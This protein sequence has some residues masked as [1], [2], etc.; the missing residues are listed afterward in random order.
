LKILS[1]FFFLQSSY[2]KNLAI[3]NWDE[4]KK[5]YSQFIQPLLEY[6]T[7]TPELEFFNLYSTGCV[8]TSLLNIFKNEDY[9]YKTIRKF[10]SDQIPEEEVDPSLY[11]TLALYNIGFGKISDKNYYIVNKKPFDFYEA[12]SKEKKITDEQK[13]ALE[14]LYIKYGYDSNE[15]ICQHIQFHNNYEKLINKVENYHFS[16]TPVGKQI[17]RNYIELKLGISIQEE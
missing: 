15:L 1:L 3:S 10:V 9:F 12:L 17:A 13:E 6:D 7:Q 14:K 16:F 2:F 11:Q 5:M 8:I 4:F